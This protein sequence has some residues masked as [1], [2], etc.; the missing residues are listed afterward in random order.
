MVSYERSHISLKSSRC[1]KDEYLKM[2][3]QLVV[4]FTCQEDEKYT[5]F[6]QGTCVVLNLTADNIEARQSENIFKLSHFE[7]K[8]IAAECIVCA[9]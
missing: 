2:F 5:L 8:I 1:E 9:I 4:F 3:P 6:P 7:K